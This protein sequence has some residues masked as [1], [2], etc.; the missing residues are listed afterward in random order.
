MPET[1]EL[2]EEKQ[3]TEHKSPILHRCCARCEKEAGYAVGFC[4]TR[5]SQ[6]GKV[7][8]NPNP[9]DKCAMC[10]DVAAGLPKGFCPNGHQERGL[11]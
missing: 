5:L 7:Y 8:R 3:E 9:P 4:G 2:V 10:M 6:A 1:L 11:I